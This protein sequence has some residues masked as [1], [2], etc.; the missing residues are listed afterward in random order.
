MSALIPTPTPPPTEP[1]PTLAPL[2]VREPPFAEFDYSWI[3]GSNRQPS[4]LLGLGPI[5]FL[6]YADAYYLFQFHQPIDHTAF[7]STVAPRHNEI[8]LNLATFG[9]ELSRLS[10]GRYGGPIGRLYLQYGSNIDT[11]AGADASTTRGYYL[12]ASAFKYIQQA[13][14]GWHF[15]TLH[16]IN[17]EMGIFPSYIGADSYLP[18]E[19]WDYLHPFIAE[20]T[21]FYFSGIRAQIYPTQRLKV[22]LWLVNGWQTFGQWHEGRSG[23]YLLNW[24]PRQ[25]LTMS[26]LFYVGQDVQGDSGGVRYYTDNNLQVQLW[27]G[28]NSHQVKSLAIS[29]TADYGFEQRGNAPSGSMTGAA[30]SLRA[31]WTEHWATT[32]RGDIFYDQTRALL[33]QL[34]SGAALPPTPTSF[35]GGGVTA[36]MDCFPS[37]WLLM[38]F[39]YMHRETNFPYFSGSAGITGPGGV[40]PIGGTPFVPDL[41]KRDDRLVLNATLRL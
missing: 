13:A 35:L 6:L 36:T 14:A 12:S 37:P 19:N 25:A 40:V 21:P 32:I 11:D 16:G 28:Q 27:R 26:H 22:E 2:A 15:N 18:Q 33:I 17:V 31:E 9:I 4:P 10:L 7:P 3:T 30:F 34:P 20:F 39:E 38:R 5:D 29:L 8:S 24:R 23:G 41:V 1:A